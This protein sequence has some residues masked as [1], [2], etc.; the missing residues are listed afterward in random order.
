V[1]NETRPDAYSVIAEYY[2]RI[3]A[4][5]FDYSSLARHLESIIARFSPHPGKILELGAGSCP[6]ARHSAYPASAMSVFSDLSPRMLARAAEG[7]ALMRAAADAGTLPFKGPFDVCVMVMDALNYLLEEKDV[8]G[9]FREVLRV[10]EPGGLFIVNIASESVCRKNMKDFSLSGIVS[11]RDYSLQSEYDEGTR[12]L[13]T[14]FTLFP[15][16]PGDCGPEVEL[17]EQHIY[18][19]DDIHRLALAAGFEV[20]GC[21]GDHT[22]RPAKWSSEVIHFA[23]R[24]PGPHTA[25]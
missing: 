18:G 1:A 15:A 7:D 5:A 17:H 20:C 19:R 2:D 13:K 4:A 16:G 22:L 8:S 21:F 23:L 6:L 3:F 14:R 11:G 25:S 12:R 24:K 9:C 10:L